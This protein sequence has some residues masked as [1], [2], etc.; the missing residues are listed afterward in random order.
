M[1]GGVE[2]LADVVGE[3]VSVGV[4]GPVFEGGFEGGDADV[5]GECC[6]GG[7]EAA[8]AQGVGEGGGECG[9]FGQFAFL[10]AGVGGDDCLAL[11]YQV[12]AF[13]E[14]GAAW[15]RAWVMTSRGGRS[16]GALVVALV[17]RSARG[18]LLGKRTS[19][20]SV[21]CRKKVRSVSPAR[22]AISATV[23]A[24]KPLAL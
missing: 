7:V 14:E 4:V 19:R 8:F 15:V 5:C 1:L 22:A 2:G 3:G 16:V 20:L 23:V 24:S 11:A 17:S 10:E 18:L 6:G 12:C 9:E 21:K 13:F